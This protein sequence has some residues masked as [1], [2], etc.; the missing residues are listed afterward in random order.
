MNSS[1]R[2]QPGRLL[3]IDRAQPLSVRLPAGFAVHCIAG[4]VWLTQEGLLDDI[5]LAAGNEFA[6]QARGLVV[7]SGIGGAALVYLSA[8]DRQ[9]ARGSLALT[10]DF[11]DAAKARATELRREEW[12]RLSGLAWRFVL[13][14]VKRTKAMLSTGSDWKFS[15]GLNARR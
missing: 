7:M 15:S 10:S 12:S 4:Q 9:R 14:V 11:L 6:V 13:R 2:K 8:A 5:L 3:E 1:G